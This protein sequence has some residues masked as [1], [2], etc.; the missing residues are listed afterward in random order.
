MRTFNRGD[1]VYVVQPDYLVEER[2]AALCAGEVGLAVSFECYA[3]SARVH[4][5]D[6]N[7]VLWEIPPV[8]ICTVPE[9]HVGDVYKEPCAA[10]GLR[11]IFVPPKASCR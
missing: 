10:C 3:D 7:G 4:V 8:A 1:V 6:H 9:G 5:T 11:L 2:M